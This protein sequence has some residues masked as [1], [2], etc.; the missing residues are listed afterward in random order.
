[1]E[2]GT[3]PVTPTARAKLI[4]VHGAVSLKTL[5]RYPDLWHPDHGIAIEPSCKT[6]P[7][8][9]PT[10][11]E[12]D[13]SQNEARSLKFA[14]SEEFYT[15]EQNM[16]GD[17]FDAGLLDPLLALPTRRLSNSDLNG[18]EGIVDD[19]HPLAS[20]G[21]SLL[22]EVQL[23][24]PQVVGE[25]ESQGISQWMSMQAIGQGEHS[26]VLSWLR[27]LWDAGQTEQ[28]EW[29]CLHHPEWGVE[30][31]DTGPIEVSHDVPDW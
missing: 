27:Q 29:W 23:S 7:P 2:T 13:D 16:K 4:A 5:Y 22:D 18:N 3:L 21:L 14:N 10:A 17:P 9:P 6:P 15:I 11:I 31:E 25:R 30:V 24:F 8:E 28:V 19:V 20:E 26:G 1:M 12:N